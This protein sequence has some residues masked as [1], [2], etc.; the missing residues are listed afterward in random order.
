VSIAHLIIIDKDGNPVEVIHDGNGN[1]LAPVAT[2]FKELLKADHAPS[3]I[4]I[5]LPSLELARKIL[6]VLARFSSSPRP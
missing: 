3:E 5:Q 2:T 4:I 1:R 6:K